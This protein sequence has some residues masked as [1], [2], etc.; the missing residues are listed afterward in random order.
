MRLSKRDY[1][2]HLA[3]EAAIRSTCL[4]RQYGAILVKDDRVI[5]TGY[6]GS[7]RGEAN[8]CDVGMCW[9]QQNNIPH[10]QQ[11]EQCVAIHA[12]DNCI[13]SAGREAIGATLY[14]AGWENGKPI[15]A[16]PCMMC[17]RKIKN[18]GIKEVITYDP[19]QPQRIS[20]LPA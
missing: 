12:E 1:Y 20:V 16:V 11:Y 14:L 9:R 15:P 17:R 18:S 10:G 3:G 5:S 7:P 8:C 13:T 19:D 6:N 4:R 2:L